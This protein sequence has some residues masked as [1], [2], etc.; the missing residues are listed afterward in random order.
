[1]N[2]DRARAEGLTVR[3]LAETAADSLR[4]WKAQAVERRAKL[5]AAISADREVEL[6]TA[7]HARR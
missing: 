4:W 7:W 6:L 2:G 3:P 1:M 5:G